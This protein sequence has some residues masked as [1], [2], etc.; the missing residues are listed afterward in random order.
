MKWLV[1]LG[2]LLAVPVVGA[3]GYVLLKLFLVN[4]NEFTD[5]DP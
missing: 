1:L 5:F 4:K 2:V 3:T